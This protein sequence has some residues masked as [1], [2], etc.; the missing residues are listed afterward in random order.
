M[1]DI[2]PV[3]TKRVFHSVSKSPTTIILPGITKSVLPSDPKP[4]RSSYLETI[5]NMAAS[6]E[7]EDKDAPFLNK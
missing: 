7:Y 5:A 4:N 6:I 3:K 1:S 2:K